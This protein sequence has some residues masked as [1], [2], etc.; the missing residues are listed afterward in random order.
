MRPDGLIYEDVQK[1]SVQDAPG[2]LDIYVAGFPCQPFSASGKWQGLADEGGRGTIIVNVAAYIDLHRPCIFIL[3]NVEGLVNNM[4]GTFSAIVNLL[5]SIGGLGNKSAYEV[6][7]NILS[8]SDHGGLPQ[9]RRRLYL[10]GVARAAMRA[11]FAWPGR[12]RRVRPLSEVLCG[13]TSNF[14]PTTT[15][16]KLKNILDCTIKLHESGEED[17]DWIVDAGKSSPSMMKHQCPC[18]TAS[19][20]GDLAFWST[21]RCRFLD[22]ADMLSLQ[23]STIKDF[24]GWESVVSQRQMGMMIGNAMSQNVLERVMRC[25][26]LSAGGSV[27]EDAW[28]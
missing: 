23:G 12:V 4:G 20:A 1:R 25:A 9:H 14:P 15:K 22:I 2:N 3:E 26:I 28:A 24:V 13:R 6:H 5:R 11:P 21:K 8:T 18:L 7:W 19:H 27:R 17:A 10:V 16:T